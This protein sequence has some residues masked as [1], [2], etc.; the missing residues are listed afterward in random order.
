[1]IS[2]VRFEETRA[3]DNLH[4]NPSDETPTLETTKQLKQQHHKRLERKKND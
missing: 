4:H 3:R 1:M 2:Q